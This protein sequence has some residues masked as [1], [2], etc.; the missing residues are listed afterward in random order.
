MLS[1]NVSKVKVIVMGRQ[2]QTEN[3]AAPVKFPHVHSQLGLGRLP[4]LLTGTFPNLPFYNGLATRYFPDLADAAERKEKAIFI[5]LA[6]KSLEKRHSEP[7]T[8]RSQRLLQK[9]ARL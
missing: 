1:L 3:F 2:K 8:T 5:I 6:F 4:A 9:S 7:Q